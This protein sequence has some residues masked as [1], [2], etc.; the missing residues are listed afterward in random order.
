MGNFLLGCNYW[1]SNAGMRM[2][3]M[4][5]A[6]VLE[7]DF[8]LLSKCGVDTIRVFPTWN[9]FQ[10]I[11]DT[12]IKWSKF[13]YRINDQPLQTQGGLDAKQMQNFSVMLTLAEKY[14]LKV[15]VAL[16]TG[17]MSGGMFVPPFLQGEDLIASPKALVWECRFIREFVQAFKD[18]N[19]IIAWEPGNECNAM[20]FD[21]TEDQN[22]LWLSA[23][24]SAIR[25]ADAT[26]PVYAGM[27]SLTSTGA[28]NL[29]QT[30][31]YT[32]IQTTH[33]YPA[34]TMYCNNEPMTCM[35]AALHAAAESTYYSGIAKQPC[36]VEEIGTLG[37]IRLNE[38][39]EAEYFEKALVTAY[40]FGTT[41]FLWWCAFDQDR[42]DFAPYDVIAMEQN[43]GLFKF[44]GSAKPISKM[45]KK[46]KAQLKEIGALPPPNKHALVILTNSQDEWAVAYGSFMMAVQEGYAVD[47]AYESQEFGE[48][49]Y[50]ILPCLVGSNGLPKRQLERLLEKIKRGAKLLITY[51]SGYIGRFE[52]LTGLKSCGYEITNRT[53][54]ILLDGKTIEI[55]SIINLHTKAVTA[56][57]LSG[58]RDK[59]LFTKNAFGEGEIYF[60]NAPI[61]LE[62]S[63]AHY[64]E[65]LGYTAVYKAFFGKTNNFRLLS[66]KVVA[67][68]HKFSNNKTGVFITNF[69]G[70][71]EVAYTLSCG[72][73]TNAKFCK[74]IEGKL[75]FENTFAYLIIEE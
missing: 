75:V 34:F 6:A 27:H 68:E 60:L 31:Y 47:F 8:Q 21:T 59:T 65:E 69:S 71:N 55:P 23:I 72:S 39:L 16:I 4:F 73:I 53:T 46:V 64:P 9:A 25:E 24:T 54:N 2:W 51:H 32:D 36:L 20:S 17:W 3:E 62:Y 38:E 63:K 49:D 1:A 42:F 56:E 37:P 45:M 52:E 7:R 14:Q 26:R 35:R 61:E 28:W 11:E 5:D 40:Q 66:D 43:L 41:G 57:V 12:K 48:Y 50:Y 15:I 30:G 10:P 19:V 13:R 18:S 44:D 33:P 58:E 29:F 70:Q 74:A 22:E 67:T